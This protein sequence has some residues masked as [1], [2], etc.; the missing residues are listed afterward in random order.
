[1]GD[2]GHVFIDLLSDGCLKL[3]LVA[4][5]YEVVLLL[6]AFNYFRLW[7]VLACFQRIDIA[8]GAV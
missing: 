3:D 4:S 8:D 5:L 6:F 1:M 2:L 7:L